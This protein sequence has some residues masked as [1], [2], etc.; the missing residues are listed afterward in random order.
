MMYLSLFK[1]SVPTL[2]KGGAVALKSKYAEY[3]L[4]HN[5]F[6]KYASCFYVVLI[7]FPSLSKKVGLKYIYFT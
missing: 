7:L 2:L 3:A 1:Y 6:N 4:M 5:V